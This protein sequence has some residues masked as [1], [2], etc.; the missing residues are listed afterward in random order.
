MKRKNKNPARFTAFFMFLAS[1]YNHRKFQAN[2][3][4]H[5]EYKTILRPVFLRFTHPL[6][7]ALPD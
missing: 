3:R 4:P 7:P 5:G 1:L 2:S 6:H